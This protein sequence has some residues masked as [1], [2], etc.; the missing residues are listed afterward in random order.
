M[1][2]QEIAGVSD[3]YVAAS[4]KNLDDCYGSK[5]RRVLVT[6]LKDRRVAFEDLPD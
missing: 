3:E 6:R 2:L 5:E 4:L 1:R